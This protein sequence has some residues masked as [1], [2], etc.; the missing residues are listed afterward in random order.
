MGGRQ[1]DDTLLHIDHHQG[2]DGVEG[3]QGHGSSFGLG[4]LGGAS[5]RRCN[6]A[7]ADMMVRRSS[8]WSA[9]RAP[10]SRCA[11]AAMAKPMVS[12]GRS[13]TTRAQSVGQGEVV[14]LARPYSAAMRGSVRSRI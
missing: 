11:L 6:T 1:G 9:A 12:L 8:G 2:G 10:R 7:M 14:I 5:A 4:G 13:I 3:A